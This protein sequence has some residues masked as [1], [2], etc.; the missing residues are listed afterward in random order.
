M[1]CFT[2][3]GGTLGNGNLKLKKKRQK[4][5]RNFIYTNNNI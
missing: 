3:A 1:R 4:N 2:N 5:N